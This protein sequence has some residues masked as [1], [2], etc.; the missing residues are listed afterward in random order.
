MSDFNHLISQNVSIEIS[1]KIELFGKLI[2]AGLDIVV[3]YNRQYFY[4]PIGHIQ[5]I[6]LDTQNSYDW[7]VDFQP[8]QPIITDLIPYPY[9]KILTNAKGSFVSLYIAGDKTIHGYLTSVM[10][11]YFVF[12]P[13]RHNRCIF[14]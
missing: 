9:R 7:D 1:G 13:L 4:I 6:R 2:D 10:N 11:D 3:I 12:S 14:L 8:V 5:R